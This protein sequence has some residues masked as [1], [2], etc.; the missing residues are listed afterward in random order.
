MHHIFK[1]SEEMAESRIKVPSRRRIMKCPYCSY[2]TQNNEELKS[3]V[4]DVHAKNWSPK[5]QMKCKLCKKEFDQIEF[6][7]RHPCQI[8]ININENLG[9]LSKPICPVCH[10]ELLDIDALKVHY[11]DSH[12][13]T[14]QEAQTFH[15]K[16]TVWNWKKEKKPKYICR[17]CEREYHAQELLDQH[18]CAVLK[19]IHKN[20]NKLIKTEDMLIL[21]CPLCK[22][23][24]EN[25]VSEDIICPMLKEVLAR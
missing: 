7:D 9:K 25:F 18:N 15:N 13:D 12:G 21:E 11:I 4:E 1:L 3:H 19:R 23:C 24:Q 14:C 20:L 2:S 22:F 6:L 16:G 10:L 8:L 5:E 17:L